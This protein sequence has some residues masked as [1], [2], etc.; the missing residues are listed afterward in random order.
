M[1]VIAAGA[2]AITVNAVMLQK[3]PHP[4]P[5]GFARPAATPVEITSA[6]ALPMPVARP[7]SLGIAVPAPDAAAKRPRSPAVAFSVRLP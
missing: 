5:F 7:P 2:V 6:V 3:G 4:A 1:V